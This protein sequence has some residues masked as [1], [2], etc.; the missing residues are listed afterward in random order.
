MQEKQAQTQTQTQT[1]CS[2]PRCPIHGQLKARGSRL[3]GLVVSSK[4]KKTAIVKVDY[5]LYLY[6]YERYLRKHS[7]I[8]AHNPE[9]IGAKVGDT[10]SVAET[11]RLSKTKSFAIMGV[12]KQHEARTA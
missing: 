8:A 10:V 5:T 11:R 3:T 2:D 7:R 4:A 12:L 6:K 1:Q 9:C